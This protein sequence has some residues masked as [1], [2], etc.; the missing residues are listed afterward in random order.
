[1]VGDKIRERRIELGMTQEELANKMGFKSKTTVTK[2]EN[3]INDVNQKRIV[4]YAKALNTT[5]AYLMGW[6]DDDN[7]DQL[8]IMVE[9]ITGEHKTRPIDRILPRLLEL[10]E[11]EVEIIENLLDLFVTK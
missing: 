10:N 6:E 3:N 1:M 7:Q 4:E 2:V 9:Q 8:E 5:P 11:K